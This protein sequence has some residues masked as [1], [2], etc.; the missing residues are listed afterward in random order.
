MNYDAWKTQLPE[1]EES[2]DPVDQ[3]LAR[4]EVMC[5]LAGLNALSEIARKYPN[6]ADKAEK[7]KQFFR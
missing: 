5:S 6:L 7:A 1:G 3:V 2:P 4:A